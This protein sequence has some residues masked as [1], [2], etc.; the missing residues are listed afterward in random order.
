MN[1]QFS[2]IQRSGWLGLGLGRLG[3]CYKFVRY[4]PKASSNI[5]DDYFSKCCSE[6]VNSSSVAYLEISAE[7]EKE[8]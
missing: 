6:L 8:S 5:C 7:N 4:S 2:K 3:I 1:F